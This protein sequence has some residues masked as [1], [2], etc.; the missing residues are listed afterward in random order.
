MLTKLIYKL[1][2]PCRGFKNMS[3]LTSEQRGSID[4]TLALNTEDLGSILA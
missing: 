3:F 2:I 1:F 4:S